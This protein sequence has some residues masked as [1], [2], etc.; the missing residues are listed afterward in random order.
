MIKVKTK[1]TIREATCGCCKA[2]LEFESCDIQEDNLGDPFVTCPNCGSKVWLSWDDE[3][4]KEKR[5][6]STNLAYPSDFYHFGGAESKKIGATETQKWCREILK[7]LEDDPDETFYYTGSGD[8]I[9]IGVR[10]GNE[11]EIYV[12]HGYD[13]C[14]V[15]NTE[16]EAE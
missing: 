11:I 10:C 7:K 3:E 2:Q 12:A 8:T 4:E 9:V 14:T 16:E 13:N 1:P 6:T 15:F 5:I